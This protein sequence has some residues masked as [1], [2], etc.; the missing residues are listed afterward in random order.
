MLHLQRDQNC[1]RTIHQD[2]DCFQRTRQQFTFIKYYNAEG[3]RSIQSV[4][5]MHCQTEIK[6][7]TPKVV[8]ED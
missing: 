7:C 4:P 3:F 1:S 5:S 8:E 2:F 6:L